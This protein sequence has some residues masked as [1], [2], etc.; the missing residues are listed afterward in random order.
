MAD[1]PGTRRFIAQGFAR[2][3]R[4]RW[5]PATDWAALL[6]RPLDEV[7]RELGIDVIPVYE[8]VYPPRPARAAA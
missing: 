3:R 5:L 1:I 4:A 6:P 2:G 7:R 8:P